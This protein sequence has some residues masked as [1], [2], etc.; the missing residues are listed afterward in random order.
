[1]AQEFLRNPQKPCLKSYDSYIIIDF[2]QV[3]HFCPNVPIIL[4]GNKKDLR[5]DTQT[6]RD[7]ARNKQ[8]PV[9]VDQGKTIGEQIGAF[10]YLECS[11]KTKE[12]CL[13]CVL[14]PVITFHNFREFVKFLKKQLK[15]PFNKRRKRSV[16]VTFY[17]LIGDGDA[18]AN[19]LILF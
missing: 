13:L 19:D 10:A 4:V 14:N 5:S 11:A 18:Q 17:N 9:T 12:A 3:R 6:I 1:M 7:L 2:F 15:Q 8:V 16:V